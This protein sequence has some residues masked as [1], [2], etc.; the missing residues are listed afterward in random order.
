MM[1][2]KY[3]KGDSKPEKSKLTKQAFE[4]QINAMRDPCCTVNGG[5]TQPMMIN[6][7]VL[8]GNAIGADH[9]TLIKQGAK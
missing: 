3:D 8:G 1:I 2:G 5:W 4:M 6:M 7:K 9:D